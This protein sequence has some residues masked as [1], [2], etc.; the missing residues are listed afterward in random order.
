VV[1]GAYTEG[2]ITGGGGRN[3]VVGGGENPSRGAQKR[4]EETWRERGRT[5]S[6]RQCCGTGTRTVG[7]V[8]FD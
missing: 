3:H 4:E 8:T 5:S 6:E 2:G 1:G 7:T